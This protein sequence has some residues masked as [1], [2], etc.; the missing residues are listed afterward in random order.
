MKKLYYDNLFRQEHDEIVINNLLRK[1]WAEC[2]TIPEYNSE[3]QIPQWVNHRWIIVN[4][5]K[6]VPNKIPLWAFR[7]ILRLN[8]LKNDVDAIIDNLPE[9]TRSLT[10]EQYEYGNYIVRLHPLI[11]N[12]G[13]QLGLT[14]DDIDNLFI[15]AKQLT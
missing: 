10:I 7:T 3:T 9:P 4:I 15:N 2:P 14:S 8:N 11:V 12:I 6:R 13:T 1:G 5:P